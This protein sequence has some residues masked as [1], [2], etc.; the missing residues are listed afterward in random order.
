LYEKNRFQDKTKKQADQMMIESLKRMVSDLNATTM[1]L[2]N[3][4]N[5]NKLE[6][7]KS[8]VLLNKA[9]I[10]NMN[11]SAHLHSLEKQLEII[12]KDNSETKQEL[13]AV[14]SQ[15]TNAKNRVDLLESEKKDIQ[16][17]NIKLKSRLETAEK[18]IVLDKQLMQR[19]NQEMINTGQ[20]LE[21]IQIENT[22]MKHELVTLN[23]KLDSMQTELESTRKSINIDKQLVLLKNQELVAEKSQNLSLVKKNS[24][25]ECEISYLKQDKVNIS[26]MERCLNEE[27]LD[28]AKL[29]DQVNSLKKQ[30]ESLQNV[31]ST[32]RTDYE[33]SLIEMQQIQKKLSDDNLK[34]MSLKNQEIDEMRK[35]ILTFRKK[36]NILEREINAIVNLNVSIASLEEKIMATRTLNAQQTEEVNKLNEERLKHFDKIACNLLKEACIK[37]K[38]VE[39][40]EANREERKSSKKVSK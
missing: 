19:Q 20:K 16:Q 28:K 22:Q 31:L 18:S 10:E 21:S 5:S 14:N 12:K 32:N 37:R 35:S 23:E 4:N 25:L 34:A 26:R 2:R 9:N 40:K 7:E 17:E 24:S 1:E 13:A 38:H 6:I 27:K 30:L 33:A 36:V 3:L 11:L 29:L 8:G 39:I 15:C